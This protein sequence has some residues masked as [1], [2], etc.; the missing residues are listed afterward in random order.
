MCK[1]AGFSRVA[2][3]DIPEDGF[4]SHYLCFK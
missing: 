3:V 2:V 4:N 1:E